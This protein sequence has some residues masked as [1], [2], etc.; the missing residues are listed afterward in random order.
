MTQ[1]HVLFFQKR[2]FGFFLIWCNDKFK[3]IIT[4][5]SMCVISEF[6]H[7]IW[8]TVWT[9]NKYVSKLLTANETALNLVPQRPT[10]Q[11][12]WRVSIVF[13]KLM[14]ILIKPIIHFNPLR[15]SRAFIGAESD[16]G[17][18]KAHKRTHVEAWNMFRQLI[19]EIK[20][21]HSLLSMLRN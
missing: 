2:L 18:S 19:P 10:P 16:G 3:N 11:P 8:K 21:M 9:K 7:N 1:S 14:V 20:T 15:Q 6:N 5:T 17:E 12:T 4:Q 13:P